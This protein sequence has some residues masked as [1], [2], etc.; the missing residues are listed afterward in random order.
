LNMRRRQRM[1]PQWVKPKNESLDFVKTMG[2]L[3][4]QKKDHL[5]LARKMGAYFLDHIRSRYKLGTLKL[6]DNFVK[7]LEFKTGYHYNNIKQL[8]DFINF[9]EMAPAVSDGQL[10][11]F[12]KQLELFYQN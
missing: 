12:H 3:Y 8:V 1:I 2:R 11:E 10:A 5:N 7:D 6:D 9:L 4:Y